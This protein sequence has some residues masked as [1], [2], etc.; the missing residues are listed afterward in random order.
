MPVEMQIWPVRAVAEV[1][2]TRPRSDGCPDNLS[3]NGLPAPLGP[4]TAYA[5]T[6]LTRKA[7]AWFR[8]AVAGTEFAVGSLPPITLS[9]LG[10]RRAC[11]WATPMRGPAARHA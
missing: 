2:L 4:T 11:G 8:P 10:R 6:A 3:L 1:M 9:S 7:G 5:L